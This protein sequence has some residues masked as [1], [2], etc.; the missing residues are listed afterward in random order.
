M[1]GG[2]LVGVLDAAGD[3]GMSG[4]VFCGVGDDAVDVG[5]AD[6]GVFKGGCQASCLSIC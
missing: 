2:E 3:A 6:H 5:H 1:L 4:V